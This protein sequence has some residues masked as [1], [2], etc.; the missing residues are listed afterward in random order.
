MH[1][2][3]SS[4]EIALAVAIVAIGAALQ[5]SVGFGFAL[6]SAP[7]LEWINPRLVPGPLI[8]PVTVLLVLT[9]LR[10]RQSIDFRGIGWVLA[11]RVP[12][13][14]IGAVALAGLSERALT[15]TLG[16]LVL[17][18]VGLSLLDVHLP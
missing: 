16:V 9:A 15:I 4:T 17:S 18:A 13:T 2:F 12:G 3:A 6:L 5:G 14:L 11:G 10:E 1:G 7:F 8:L